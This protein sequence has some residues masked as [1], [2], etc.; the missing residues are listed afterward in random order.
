MMPTSDLCCRFTNYYMKVQDGG[1]IKKCPTC[2][3][4]C[5]VR[6]ADLPV[7]DYMQLMKAI[8]ERKKIKLHYAELLDAIKC[9]ESDIH[10][11]LDENEKQLADWMAL[12]EN[13]FLVV[14]QRHQGSPAVPNGTESNTG[15][16]DADDFFQLSF[17]R[18]TTVEKTSQEYDQKIA[19]ITAEKTDIEEQRKMRIYVRMCDPSKKDTAQPIG[20]ILCEG[21][22]VNEL[23]AKY[24]SIGSA[25]QE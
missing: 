22:V 15:S 20:E 25:T 2:H 17:R 1:T 6:V 14:E 4:V 18:R 23:E 24:E 9:I 19:K 16:I 8:E 7:N 13:N 21:F 10:S 3:K 5:D 12:S 11:K